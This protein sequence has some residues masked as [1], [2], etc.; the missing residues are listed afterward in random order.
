MK[1]EELAGE[2]VARFVCGGKPLL[3]A[4]VRVGASLHE[5]PRDVIEAILDR[6]VQRRASARVASVHL[7]GGVHE[8]SVHDWR[9]TVCDSKM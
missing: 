1:V 5:R 2:L 4:H 8:D 9:E 6:G 7:S 3:V